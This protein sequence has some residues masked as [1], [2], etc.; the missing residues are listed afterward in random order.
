MNQCSNLS[1]TPFWKPLFIIFLQKM[2][3]KSYFFRIFLWYQ[4][5][6]NDFCSP[7]PE[8]GI[9]PKNVLIFKVM[10]FSRIFSFKMLQSQKMFW[11]CSKF[12][13]FWC[14][15]LWKVTY[16]QK[17]FWNGS[18]FYTLWSFQ[19]R[20]KWLLVLIGKCSNLY[21]QEEKMFPIGP[22]FDDVPNTKIQLYTS[23]ATF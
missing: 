5:R 22:Q 3:Q 2:A 17:M 8:F 10:H 21:C 7:L 11:I 4:S 20:K 12:C 15:L 9:F 14:F 6:H 18:K 23:S 1:V 16:I 13:L 19:L